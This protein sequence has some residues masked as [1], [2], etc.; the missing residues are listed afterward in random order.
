MQ[1]YSPDTIQMPLQTLKALENLVQTNSLVS[2]LSHTYSSPDPTPLQLY[3][4]NK[5][6]DKLLRAMWWDGQYSL[7]LSDQRKASLRK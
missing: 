1:D 4:G 3:E 2:H 7:R 5:Q 6:D